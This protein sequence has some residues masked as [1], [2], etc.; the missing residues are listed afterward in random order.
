MRI[1]TLTGLGMKTR[2]GKSNNGERR[3]GMSERGKKKVS[4][5]DC[6]WKE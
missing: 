6:I 3:M 1:P 2:K 4:K 5:S